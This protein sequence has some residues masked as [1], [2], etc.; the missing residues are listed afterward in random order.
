MDKMTAGAE[1]GALGLLSPLDLLPRGWQTGPTGLPRDQ[2][3][4]FFGATIAYTWDKRSTDEFHDSG[5]RVSN[6][7]HLRRPRCQNFASR[8]P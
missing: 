2:V 5:F 1:A 4:R 6:E 7:R 3:Q 8:K